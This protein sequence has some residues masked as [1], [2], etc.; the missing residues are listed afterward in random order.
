MRSKHKFIPTQVVPMEER[1]LLSG[2][3]FP[4]VLGPVVTLGKHGAFVLTSDVYAS[5]HTDV[6][7]DINSFINSVSKAYTK[8]L[9]IPSPDFTTFATVV[10]IGTLGTGPGGGYAS[11]SLLAILDSKLAKQEF[12][13][14][15]GAGFDD[16]TGGV[17]LSVK[18]AATSKNPASVNLGNESVAELME[19]A[20]TTATTEQEAL[21]AMNTVRLETLQVSPTATVPV[22]GIIPSYIEFFGPGN[23]RL[24]GLSNS[25]N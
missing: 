1:A 18:T 17:G 3:R 5:V 9:N 6:N 19:D 25:N 14:P 13:L 23:E 20:I 4:V 10:G 2:F 24:F 22:V 8:Y 11:G 12:R 7:N 15:F 21:A 16:V